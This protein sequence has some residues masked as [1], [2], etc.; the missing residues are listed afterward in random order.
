MSVQNYIIV[1]LFA[2]IVA[3]LFMALFSQRKKKIFAIWISCILI[4]L[5][6]LSS[7]HLLLTS[8]GLQT[9]KLFS[10]VSLQGLNIELSFMIDRVSVIMSSAVTLVSFVVFVYSIY[11]MKH[12]DGINRFFSYLG[13]FV[14]SM[15]VLVLS[16]NF[17]GLFIGWEGVGLC[18]WLL[19]GFW[20]GKESATKA[21]NE[22]F[23]TNRIADVFM[24]SG[25]FL[26]YKTFGSLSYVDVFTSINNASHMDLLLIS[27]FLFI[28]AMG[29]SAQFPFHNWLANAMEGPTPVSALIHAATMVTAGVYLVIRCN[30]IYNHVP[31]MG[32]FIACLG[33]FVAIF[34][35]SM[36]LVHKDMKRVIA[37]STLSQ[38]GYMFAAAGLGAYVFALFHLVMHAF[39]K[40]LLFLCAGNVMHAMEGELNIH[41]MGALYKNM[42]MTALFM[43]IGS[44]ALCGIYPFA[45]YFS[46]DK[47]LE[48][49][50][51]SNHIY[52]YIVL[53]VGAAF[54]AFYSFRL[55]MLIF[56]TKK[57]NNIEHPPE[58][59]TYVFVFLGILAVLSV[60][61]GFSR[62][63][64][65]LY[66]KEYLPSFSAELSEHGTAYM[67]I[68]IIVFVFGSIAFAI[69]AYIKGLFK[70][71]IENNIVY[72]ILANEYYIPKFYDKVVIR[73]YFVICFIASAIDSFI[74]FIISFI[75]ILS[76]K[77]GAIWCKTNDG[78]ISS[79]L[80]IFIVGF[81]VIIL[82]FYLYI[83][84]EL[85]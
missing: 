3:S 36:A 14:F 83:F 35:A 56:F 43:L 13:A 10:W 26:I 39:F 75:V 62:G 53:L 29:K 27:I 30:P 73:F 55:L 34:A 23:I 41:K 22:A 85:V 16:D 44:L 5:S 18:S 7:L 21:A 9:L 49:S 11:Y 32:Y 46:K 47:I 70:K 66:I 37:Y 1:L 2:P 45:G 68:S 67:Q 51:S 80:K 42:K 76:K 69:Y 81:A 60:I 84:S 19:I 33:S 65:L 38:L 57:K 58:A 24:L 61:A 63:S 17:L 71:D 74:S 28:G 12:D 72:K 31:N 77:L 50:L 82:Y 40:S 52:M 78:N 59:P 6:F 8:D 48:A 79:M 4:L 15:L 54:T 25:I 20:Y 64:Y